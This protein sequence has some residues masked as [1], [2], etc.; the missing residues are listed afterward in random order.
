[1]RQLAICLLI[2]STTITAFCQEAKVNWGPEQKFDKKMWG[3]NLGTSLVHHGGFSYW[4]QSGADGIHTTK[5]NLQGGLV[6]TYVTET[7]IDDKPLSFQWTFTLDGNLFATMIHYDKEGEELEVYI[8]PF[9][10]AKV[11]G[12]AKKALSYSYSKELFNHNIISSSGGYG[13]LAGLTIVRSPNLKYGAVILSTRADNDEQNVSMWVF[14][15]DLNKVWKKDYTVI[16]KGKSVVVVS[17]LLDNQGNIYLASATWDAR[18]EEIKGYNTYGYTVY[19]FNESGREK[20]KLSFKEKMPID[21]HLTKGGAGK[22]VKVAGTYAK[23]PED[24]EF[25][26]GFFFG[27]VTFDQPEKVRFFR[28]EDDILDG[29]AYEE[30]IASGKGAHRFHL[31]TVNYINGHY[32]MTAEQEG[33]FYTESRRF[34][35]TKEL[36]AVAIDP[37]G[38]LQS[39][40]KVPF[41]IYSTYYAHISHTAVSSNGNLGLIFSDVKKKSEIKELGLEGG[42]RTMFTELV[43]V[44][45][46]G[47]VD[48]QVL[49]SHEDADMYFTPERVRKIADN[50]YLLF[51]WYK[52]KYQVGTLTIE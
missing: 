47:K 15:P 1:M 30:N 31:Q 2:L 19:E 18:D 3:Y 16:G 8:V 22:G 25:V 28:L 38:K 42:K 50:K 23:R 10:G 13:L 20:V 32:W 37:E 11:S 9:N 24:Q 49:F 29:I 48:R 26:A 34:N 40:T 7:L 35:Y 46:D 33:A 27:S 43:T 41:Y 36:V 45:S 4:F 12:K 21:L 52:K 14:D 44:K 5:F 6:G 17:R 39:M 51:R